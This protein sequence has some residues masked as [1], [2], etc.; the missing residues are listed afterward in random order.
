LSWCTRYETFFIRVYTN[1]TAESFPAEGNETSA[2][3]VTR[4]RFFLCRRGRR[5]KRPDRYS[6]KIV[7]STRS[8]IV[9]RFRTDERTWSQYE[10]PSAFDKRISGFANDRFDR[11]SEVI[12]RQIR[13]KSACGNRIRC[14]VRCAAYG[15][16]P[17]LTH[18]RS[19]ST[20]TVRNTL[21]NI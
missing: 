10:Y 16:T 5:D 15:A 14:R 19:P 1:A 21:Y 7:G 17:K 9:C 8:E 12:T 6:R 18:V 4:R 20:R 13:P 2:R 11:P 3:T